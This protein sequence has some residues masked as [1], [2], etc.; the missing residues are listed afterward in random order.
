MV[1]HG[2]YREAG[3]ALHSVKKYRW[4]WIDVG[5][6]IKSLHLYHSC[7]PIGGRND[8]DTWFL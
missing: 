3:C 6:S 7:P 5:G 8:N 2:I 4:W 1:L